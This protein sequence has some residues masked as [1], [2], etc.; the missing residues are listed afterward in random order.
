MVT[1]NLNLKYSLE[2]TPL[3]LSSLS[4][5]NIMTKK[6]LITKMNTLKLT[7]KCEIQAIRATKLLVIGSILE[8]FE[9]SLI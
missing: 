4:M 6:T 7:T 3:F 5:N 8:I 1:L 9:E 2:I